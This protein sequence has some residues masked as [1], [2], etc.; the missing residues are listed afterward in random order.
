MSTVK[1]K[2]SEDNLAID[3]GEPNTL[4]IDYST[5][6]LLPIEGPQFFGNIITSFKSILLELNEFLL[7]I[8]AVAEFYERGIQFGELVDRTEQPPDPRPPKWQYDRNIVPAVNN[9]IARVN[10]VSQ[11]GFFFS[12]FGAGASQ[13]ARE[14]EEAKK[15]ILDW[16]SKPTRVMRDAYEVGL[17][18]KNYDTLIAESLI[19]ADFED[20][21]KIILS[22]FIEHYSNVA[23]DS[24][25]EKVRGLIYQ[26]F[27]K[28]RQKHTSFMYSAFSRL[29]VN[30]IDL[31]GR[32]LIARY[33][34]R[35]KRTKASDVD[36]I[37]ELL[38]FI[39]LIYVHEWAFR[40]DER[41]VMEFGT[42][43]IRGP[44]KTEA[45]PPQGS[46]EYE[47][48]HAMENELVS[49]AAQSRNETTQEISTMLR[50]KLDS[51]YYAGPGSAG[52]LTGS[53]SALTLSE[54]KRNSVLSLLHQVSIQNSNMFSD[55]S[56]TNTSVTTAYSIPGVDDKK[57]C[58][59]HRF[60]VALPVNSKIS[61]YN[62]GLS[63][64]PRI[65][66]P[67]MALRETIRRVYAETVLEYK[68]QYYVPEPVEPAVVWERY[69]ASTDKLIEE[70]AWEWETASVNESFSINVNPTPGRYD[71]PDFS[72]YSVS[73]NQNEGFFNDDP[74]TVQIWLEGLDYT[75]GIITGR[76]RMETNDGGADF[77]GTAH[78]EIPMLRWSEE[79]VSA[80]AT[81]QAQQQ[82]HELKKQAIAAQA[83]QYA[84]IKQREVIAR[85]ERL[86]S[87]I[88]IVFE[89]LIRRS[90]SFGTGASLSYYSEII[91]R[92]INWEQA[93]IIF[94]SA[95]M[96]NLHYP[97]FPPDHFMNSPAVRL[98]LPVNRRS[99]DILLDTLEE[100]GN[101]LMR[102]SVE[103]VRVKIEEKRAELEENGPELLDEFDTQVIIGDHLE[104]VLS[105]YDHGT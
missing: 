75:D 70:G 32:W 76:I 101:F 27:T 100:C 72:S 45:I 44:F 26:T 42:P 28:A 34:I 69:T 58:T 50:Q 15:K 93:K 18:S 5:D 56:L 87:I 24:I 64:T 65:L 79:T 51:V 91:K 1:A 86:D 59:V 88:K 97:E 22:K 40:R 67:F 89:E 78:I 95:N 63:W 37:I 12:L 33:L 21:C 20:R 16:L 7:I 25:N 39:P 102:N 10:M 73:W 96:A 52:D 8:N 3:M 54:Q 90:C 9:A 29:P 53:G 84:K 41:L 80:M 49:I 99:E 68:T 36:E 14:V 30:L 38:G 31:L 103:D 77:D 74:D 23:P 11:P 6:V 66:N 83:R 81:F 57:S 62:V 105:K 71:K 55:R 47:E 17:I 104:A 98:F 61:L 13:Q 46:Y 4:S 35:N 48:Y 85:H 19:K 60:K 43:D 92:C 82:E 94:E 2:P